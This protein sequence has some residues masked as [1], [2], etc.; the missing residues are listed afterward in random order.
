MLAPHLA[1]WRIIFT[2]Q[3][4]QLRE[5]PSGE[6]SALMM[7]QMLSDTRIQLEIFEDTTSESRNFTSASSFYVR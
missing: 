7:V 2:T 6:R 4:I 3:T 1:L 5:S